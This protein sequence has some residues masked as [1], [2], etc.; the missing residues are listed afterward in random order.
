MSV[1]VPDALLLLAPGCQHCAAVLEGLG[2]LVKE[3]AVGALEVVNLQR[4][5]ERAEQLQVR[6]VP[7][8][9]IGP[10]VLQGAHTLGELRDWAARAQDPASVQQYIE[11]QLNLG[12]LAQVEAML[13]FQPE[14]LRAV[15][16]LL[17][18]PDTEMQVRLGID[19]LLDSLA[20]SDVV[21]GMLSDFAELTQNPD[22]RIRADACHYIALTGEAQAERYLEV[23][24]QDSEVEVRESAEEAL[25]ELRTR[26]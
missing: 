9:R 11:Q 19:A 17:E 6:S 23:C 5:P 24:L 8:L 1:Q 20:G 15:V 25:A 2:T 18:N 22:H 21:K 14:A 10:F 16:P 4:H 3:G 12:Q 26:V 13:R 7:W